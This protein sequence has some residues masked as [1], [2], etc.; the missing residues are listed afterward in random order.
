[1]MQQPIEKLGWPYLPRAIALLVL[2]GISGFVVWSFHNANLPAFIATLIFG[3]FFSF[4]AGGLVGV[5]MIPSLGAMTTFC[6]ILEGIVQGWS[7]YGF[8]GAIAGGFFG[9]VVA[10]IVLMLPFMLIHF[11]LAVCGIDPF[12]SL[13]SPA[14]K[15]DEL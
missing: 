11:V 4:L 14:E 13:D 3:I 9:A 15:K 10:P 1:M 12:A 7:R 8:I 6:G 5:H 2:A